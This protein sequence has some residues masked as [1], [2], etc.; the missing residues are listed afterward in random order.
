MPFDEVLGPVMVP[1]AFGIAVGAMLLLFR[2][3]ARRYPSIPKRIPWRIEPDGRPAKRLI[4]KRFVWLAP[5]IV[6]IAL[7]VTG[8]F[9]FGLKPPA[10]SERGMIALVF[11]I[12]AEI[13]WLVGWSLDRQIEIARKLTYRIAPARILRAC[14]P[15]LATI[16]VLILVEARR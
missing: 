2:H 7:A 4:G 1:I 15:V 10:E 13:A 6:A 14:L 5:A 11:V 9:A 8:A 3:V 12:F 16:A